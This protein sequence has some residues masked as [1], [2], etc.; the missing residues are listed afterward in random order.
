MAPLIFFVEGNIGSGKSTFLKNMEKYFSVNT[1]F[2]Q[3]PV[4]VWK[5][6][7]DNDDNNI[8]HYFYNDMERFCYAFQ[9]FAFISRVQQIDTINTD[10]TIIFIERSVFCDRNVFASTCHESG[11]MSDIEWKIY[12]TWFSWMETKYNDIFKSAQYIYLQCSPNTSLH[13]I[14]KR[15]RSEESSI[16]IEYLSTLHNKH[17]KWLCNNS[18]VL[19]ID[20]EQNLL[21]TEIMESTVENINQY[22]KKLE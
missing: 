7:K 16:S 15:A 22:I 3:E 17:D 9:S 13:R 4:D 2:I 21:N 5:E 10:N 12:N 1:Q 11:L 14:S 18:N 8:L 20:A 6:T 19:I